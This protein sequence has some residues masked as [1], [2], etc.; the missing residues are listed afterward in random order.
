M[1]VVVWGS[2]LEFLIW[3]RVRSASEAF[4]TFGIERTG[5]KP[6]TYISRRKTFQ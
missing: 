3:L 2:R 6:G 1:H 4:P 5:L